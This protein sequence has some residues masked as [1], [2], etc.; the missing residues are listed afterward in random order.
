M[1]REFTVSQ[2]CD[3]IVPV[4]GRE[5]EAAGLRV[6]RSFD[7][8]SALAQVPTCTCPHHGT[9]RCDCEY[10]VLLVY[11]PASTPV[12]LIVHGHDRRCWITLADDP[13][14]QIV[15]GLAARIVQ[16]LA[17][18]RLLTIDATNDAAVQ[19]AALR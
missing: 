11:G 13:N 3:E 18:A 17:A 14:G 5:L 4:I 16:V 15:P 2:V 6:E 19:A 8:R 12:S 1:H 10:S 7:L 9:A